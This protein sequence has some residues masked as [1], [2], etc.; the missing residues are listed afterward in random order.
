MPT[1]VF[2][3]SNNFSYNHLLCEFRLSWTMAFSEI[4]S[5]IRQMPINELATGTWTQN[6]RMC[7]LN[8]N[9]NVVC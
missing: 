4:L 2:L 9:P 7:D 3:L 6:L 5:I 1:Q 8:V